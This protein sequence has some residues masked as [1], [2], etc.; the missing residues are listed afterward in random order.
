MTP[1]SNTGR[2]LFVLY[3][4]KREMIHLEQNFL[5]AAEWLLL[6]FV[7]SILS[8]RLGISVA[9]MEIAIGVI[10]GNALQ[11]EITPWVNFLAGFGAVVLTFLAGAE[12]D[13]ESLKANLKESL[14]IG[15]SSFLLPFLGGMA[16]AYYVFGWDANASKIAGIALSTTS[17]AVVYA[18]MV[19]SG[20]SSTRLGQAIL[21]AC[22]VTDL[23]TVIAL[24]ILFTGFSM[25]VVW[26]VAILIAVV[27]LITPVMAKIFKWYGGRVSE[28]EIKFIFLILLALAYLAVTSG[29][30]AVLPAYIIGM[31]MAG[32]FIR[33]KETL[34]KIRAIIFA[35]FTP[36]YFIK[37]GAL[38][39]FT[40]LYTMAGA[41]VCFLAVKMVAKFIG[42]LPTTSYFNYGRRTEIYTTLLM[43]T[44]LTFGTISALYG[45]SNNYI[46]QNQYSALV[47]AVI[48]SAVIPTVIAQKWFFPVPGECDDDATHL[49][50]NLK[51]K[52]ERSAGSECK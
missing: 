27:F 30:E 43:S 24:G 37:A 44:G 5:V 22:F 33:H 36:F 2:G 34:H 28:P 41:I 7:A 48:L 23:G 32:F 6:A 8:I 15:F 31:A 49:V 11:I 26:F 1:T 12:I 50:A 42:V 9:L 20:L 39:S 21:A 51:C 40:A 35:A 52:L 3:K 17:V 14:A 38:V 18:V 4:P 25:K 29:S 45:L 47:A 19:E 46:D 10:G 16:F 13:P